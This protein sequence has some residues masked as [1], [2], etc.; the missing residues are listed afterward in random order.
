M[1]EELLDCQQWHKHIIALCDPLELVHPRQHPLVLLVGQVLVVAAVVPR[2]EGVEAD[3]VEALLRD[4]GPIVEQALVEVLVV[5]P[6]HGN[7]G[8]HSTGGLIN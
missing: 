7:L 6:G 3:A 4:F 5:T 2:V 1:L 8:I